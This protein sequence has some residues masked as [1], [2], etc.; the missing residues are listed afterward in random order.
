VKLY[1]VRHGESEA[2]TRHVISNGRSTFGLTPRGQKQ[3]QALAEHIG[4]I[5][6]KTL[7]SSPILRARETADILSRA[8]GIS[9][10]VTEALREYDCGILEEKDDEESW[11]YH[12]QYF[13]DWVLHK[14]YTSKP[15]GGECFLDIQNRFVPFIEELANASLAEDDN[16]LLVG[17]GGLYLL[18]LPLVLTNVDHSFATSHGIGNAEYILAKRESTGLVCVQW[19][20]HILVDA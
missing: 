12:R 8:I 3:A 4:S 17:H 6:F 14:N 15:E 10:Q 16:F 13:E 20:E 1:F 5:P 9:Y 19:G 18:M 2:N 11:R 7:Y